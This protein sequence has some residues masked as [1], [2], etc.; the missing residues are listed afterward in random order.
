MAWRHD[1]VEWKGMST[2][3]IVGERWKV[4]GRTGGDDA[5]EEAPAN[6]WFGKST[7]TPGCHGRY[8]SADSSLRPCNN[9]GFRA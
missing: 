2:W 7:S 9:C 4:G 1:T 3:I 6:L 8:R 5:N